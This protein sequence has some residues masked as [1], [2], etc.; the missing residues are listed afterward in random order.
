VVE[1]RPEHHFGGRRAAGYQP[2]RC[3]LF[4]YRAELNGGPIYALEIC[5]SR[6]KPGE[7]DVAPGSQVSCPSGVKI[8]ASTGAWAT[9]SAVVS[10]IGAPGAPLD[11]SRTVTVVSDCSATRTL[12]SV[13]C[14]STRCWWVVV[15]SVGMCSATWRF[16]RWRPV[17][18]GGMSCPHFLCRHSKDSA[19]V[20]KMRLAGAF[21]IN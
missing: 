9:G 16:Q 6:P 13:G 20:R 8:R 3:G 5:A 11:D 10:A 7:C 17:S 14:W 4:L 2:A 18:I 19:F 21:R 15:A 1:L 12:S